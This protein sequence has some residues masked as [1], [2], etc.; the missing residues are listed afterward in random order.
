MTTANIDFKKL[1]GG[2]IYWKKQ[3]WFEQGRIG[4]LRYVAPRLHSVP[5]FDVLQ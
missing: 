1:F 2:S 5:T 4:Q 3:E